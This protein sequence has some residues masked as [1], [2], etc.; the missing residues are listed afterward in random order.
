MRINECALNEAP[1]LNG[2]IV[3]PVMHAHGIACTIHRGGTRRGHSAM[4]QRHS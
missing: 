4:Q 3:A 1:R 2:A